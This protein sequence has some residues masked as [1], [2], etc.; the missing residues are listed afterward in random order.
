MLPAQYASV[1]AAHALMPVFRSP[2]QA[3]EPSMI[4]SYSS[5]PTL[6][7]VLTTTDRSIWEAVAVPELMGVCTVAL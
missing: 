2:V 5:W 6:D 1:P 4:W 3:L 7:C